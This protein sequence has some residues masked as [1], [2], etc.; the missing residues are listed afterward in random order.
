MANPIGV[1]EILAS[2]K[3]VLLSPRLF[4]EMVKSRPQKTLFNMREA[5]EYI[6]VS[7]W[8]V[9]VLIRSGAFPFVPLGKG[10]K[11]RKRIDV[12]DIDAWIERSKVLLTDLRRRP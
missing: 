4:R 6:G 10:S 2:G 5:G 11:G 12:R 9:Q 7:R 3:P 8:Q 1:D